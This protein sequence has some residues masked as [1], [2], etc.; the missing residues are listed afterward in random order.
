MKTSDLVAVI[1]CGGKGTRYNLKNKR[2]ILKPL[3][4]I[5]GTP[6][7]E[8]VIEIYKKNNIRNFLLLGGYK[9]NDLKKNFSKKKSKLN[10]QCINTGV[11]TE[12]AGRLLFA[13]KY[14]NKKMFL[15]TYGDSLTNFDL[16]KALKLK[17]SNN[18]VMSCYNYKI[19][20]GVLSEINQ[21]EL[22]HIREKN[23][24]CLINAGFY[25]L[26]SEIFKF[27]RSKNE[28]FE[29]VTL[30]KLIL[31]KKKVKLNLLTKW[32]PMD[33]MGDKLNMERF[34]NDL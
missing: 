2:K 7:I 3:V 11:N 1:L 17:K 22:K 27:I 24:S 14:L 18:I 31:S 23:N 12:T 28:S 32:Y 21:N 8:K 19:P 15:M 25:I 9:F 30:K 5:K 10:I 26:D 33:T 16:K 34:I 29:K 20:Y 13:K 6:I 4:K